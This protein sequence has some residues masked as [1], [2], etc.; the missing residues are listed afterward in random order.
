MYTQSK[1]SIGH[2]N[3]PGFRS[4]ESVEGGAASQQA[5]G[6]TSVTRLAA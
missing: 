3:S 5:P 2:S 6:A 1:F 4:E